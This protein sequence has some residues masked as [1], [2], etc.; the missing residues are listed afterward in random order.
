MVK[1]EPFLVAFACHAWYFWTPNKPVSIHCVIRQQSLVRLCWRM[2]EGVE[3]GQNRT[4]FGRFCMSCMVFLDSK[5]AR[6]HP[7]CHS[8][9]ES[10]K[11][12]LANER[13]SRIW[14]KQNRFW[15]LLHVMHGIF[16]L[17]TSP[18]PSI[19]SFANRVL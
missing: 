17:Q 12:L 18:F 11:T 3:Y 9:T 1:T 16:G 2:K 13:R 14:S 19:V 4:V 5:Q 6:F 15:S 10:C 7:L 8:P